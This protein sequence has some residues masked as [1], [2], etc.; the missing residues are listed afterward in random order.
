MHHSLIRWVRAVSIEKSMNQRLSEAAD[1]PAS[2][3]G[4]GTLRACSTIAP[5][6]AAPETPLVAA[7]AIAFSLESRPLSRRCFGSFNTIVNIL[8]RDLRP[9]TN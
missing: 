5:P 4:C 3:A 9:Y 2:C 8:P 6:A 7:S 1:R